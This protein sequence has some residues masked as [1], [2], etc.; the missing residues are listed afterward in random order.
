MMRRPWRI[1]IT[2]PDG[3][4]QDIGPCWSEPRC[5]DKRRILEDLLGVRQ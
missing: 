2:G 4:A 3:S 1:T 5:A